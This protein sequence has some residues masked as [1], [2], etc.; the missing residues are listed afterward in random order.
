[1][2]RAGIMEQAPARE[3]VVG[4]LLELEAGDNMAADARLLETFE[5]RVADGTVD[6]RVAGGSDHG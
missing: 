6:C 3:L 4:D 5:L 1:M 2:R